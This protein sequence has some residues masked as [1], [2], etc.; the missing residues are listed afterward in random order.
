VRQAQ[1]RDGAVTAVAIADFLSRVSSLKWVLSECAS[2]LSDDPDHLLALLSHGIGRCDAALRS[3][4]HSQHAEAVN[5]AEEG[6][7]G[8]LRSQ[9][10]SQHAE[11]VHGAEE[12][13]GGLPA[14]GGNTRSNENH[15]CTLFRF[16]L[17][18]EYIN[19]D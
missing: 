12:G 6:E 7:G 16:S 13:E 9:L 8:L 15:T 11:A 2:R 3:Q 14:Y 19:L 5:G 18:S 10:D 4:L 1:W 17:L